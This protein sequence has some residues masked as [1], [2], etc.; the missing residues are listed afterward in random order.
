MAIFKILLLIGALL[1]PAAFP[2]FLEGQDTVV[3]TK[4]ANGLEVVLPVGTFLEVRLEEAGATGYTWQV[5]DLDVAHLELTESRT[6]PTG[7]PGMVGAP[8]QKTWRFKAVET[9]QTEL[10]MYYYR[11]WEGL[12]KGVEKFQVRITI[13]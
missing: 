2:A 5:I 1:I 6:T 13:L 12:D 7:Q 10:K 3:L 8:V 4:S 9:G 11:I